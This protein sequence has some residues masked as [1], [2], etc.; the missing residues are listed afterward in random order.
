MAETDTGPWAP[1]VQSQLPDKMRRIL[2]GKPRGGEAWQSAAGAWAGGAPSYVRYN[3]EDP[4]GPAGVHAE[5]CRQVAMEPGEGGTDK[6]QRALAAGTGLPEVPTLPDS[7]S[8]RHTQRHIGTRTDTHI[9]MEG[10]TTPL[11]DIRG[12]SEHR[13]SYKCHS[14]PN[15]LRHTTSHVCKHASEKPLQINTCTI[16]ATKTDCRA[17]TR[18]TIDNAA[19]TQNTRTHTH[20]GTKT[21]IQILTTQTHRLTPFLYLTRG[22]PRTHVFVWVPQ[23]SAMNMFKAYLKN[24]S[25]GVSWPMT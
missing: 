2:S 1:T 10:L 25:S 24:G 22:R 13:D 11:G 5:A 19:Q 21:R 16:P 15:K 3:D 4:P 7:T 17:H 23:A 9:R 12:P 8:A 14:Y 6:A 18:P 20:A